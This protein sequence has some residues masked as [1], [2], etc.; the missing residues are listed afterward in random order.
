MSDD[1]RIYLRLDA[2]YRIKYEELE[3]FDDSIFS[4]VYRQAAQITREIVEKNQEYHNNPKKGG[5]AYRNNE[6]IYNVISFVGERG[7]GK[8]S[9][10]LSFA[11]YLKDYFR[12]KAKKD[13]YIGDNLAFIGV[14]AIDAGL[15]EDKE[16]IVDVVLAKLLGEFQKSEENARAVKHGD[17]DYQRREFNFCLQKVYASNRRRKEGKD[18]DENASVHT[19]NEMA[20]SV[21]M[22]ESIKDLIGKY[23]SLI[24]ETHFSDS[25]SDKNCFVVIPID[26]IDM[27]ITDGYKMLEQIRRYLMVPN[28]IVLLSY[29]YR[30]LNDICD[31]YYANKF[32]NLSRVLENGDREYRGRISELSRHYMA[33][34]VPDGRRITLTTI[35]DTERLTENLVYVVPVNGEK[36]DAHSLEETIM[37]KVARCFGIRSWTPVSGMEIWETNNLRNVCNLYNELHVLKDPE[38]TEIYGRVKREDRRRI[39]ED[40]YAWFFNYLN[41]KASME[42]P[43]A[44]LGYVKR[45]MKQPLSHLN[46]SILDELDEYLNKETA[47]S[48]IDGQDYY[49]YHRQT[50]LGTSL[51]LLSNYGDMDA[52]KFITPYLGTVVA[53]LFC[54]LEHPVKKIEK[55]FGNGMGY[56][57]SLLLPEIRY[58]VDE[59]QNKPYTVPMGY[60]YEISDAV[61]VKMSARSKKINVNRVRTFEMLLMFMSNVHN[62]AFEKKGS[63]IQLKIGTC[64]FRIFNFMWNIFTFNQILGDFYG[65]FNPFLHKNGFEETEIKHMEED[66]LFKELKDWEERY[67]TNQVLPFANTEFLSCILQDCSEK[68]YDNDLDITASQMEGPDRINEEEMILNRMSTMFNYIYE[69]LDKQDKYYQKAKRMKDTMPWSLAEIFK[70]CPVIANVLNNKCVSF[71]PITWVSQSGSLRDVVEDI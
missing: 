52:N 13:Y 14:N 57:D 70:N 7:S 67:G 1:R 24:K 40:N 63:D 45:I 17:Y 48:I 42:L 50:S 69:A 18:F 44:E 23:I 62:I 47:L 36:N 39:Y 64:D 33:K 61:S 41:H 26:D 20:V 51:Y 29:K 60:I 11:E 65:R 10:M 30:Q 9:C 15:L 25:I 54:T 49:V 66:S 71:K 8:T 55:I 32:S 43:Q 22:R 37:R 35:S 68:F 16:D 5:N 27:N 31:L 4:P 21:N 46:E 38:C 56:Y 28:V 2:P 58:R 59:Y 53:N 34:V 6:Q 19:L 12:I 3:E